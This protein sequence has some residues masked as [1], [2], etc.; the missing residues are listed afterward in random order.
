MHHIVRARNVQKKKKNNIVYI[1]KINRPRRTKSNNRP[2]LIFCQ[3]HVTIT[4]VCTTNNSNTHDNDECMCSFFFYYLTQC[5][6]PPYHI[7]N[8]PLVVI[9]S[10]EHT[11]S[12]RRSRRFRWISKAYLQVQIC[13]EM[14]IQT[15]TCIYTSIGEYACITL[16]GVF[17]GIFFLLKKKKNLV[18][19]IRRVYNPILY[20]FIRTERSKIIFNIVLDR[21]TV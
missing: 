11:H 13:M 10:N 6:L 8:P 3:I 4:C 2:G 18:R 14:K 20:Y 7:S 15:K 12:Q 17:E 21:N 19:I 9:L 5:P 1:I 16:H